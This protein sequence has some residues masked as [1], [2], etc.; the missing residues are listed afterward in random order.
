[1]HNA[2]QPNLSKLPFPTLELLAE[3]VEKYMVFSAM[4]V[5]MMHMGFV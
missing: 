3:A 5:C 1:M 4:Q 2:R